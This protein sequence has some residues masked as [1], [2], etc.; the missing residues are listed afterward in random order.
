MNRS[1]SRAAGAP[2]NELGEPM[3]LLDE[4]FKHEV[5]PALGCTEPVACAYATAVA[6]SHLHDDVEEVAVRVDPGT[7][8]NGAA[9]TVPHTEGRKGNLLAAALGAMVAAPEEKLELLRKVTPEHLHRAEEL[10]RTGNC[11]IACLEGERGFRIEAR[12]SSGRHTVLA[13][14][15]HGHTNIEQVVK[16]GEEVLGGEKGDTD[17]NALAYR[18]VLRDTDLHTLLLLAASPGAERTAFLRRGVEMNQAISERGLEMQRTAHQLLRMRKKGYLADDMFFRAKLQ[19]AS[20]VDARMAGVNQAA[21]TSG[22]SGNQG[23]VATLTS[24]IVGKE[25]NVDEGRILESISAAHMMNAYVKCFVGELSVVCGCAMAAGISAAVAI[26]YQQAGVDMQ[27]IT[28][29][30]NSVIGDLGGLICDGAKP[31]CAMKAVTAVDA[32]IRSGLMALEDFGLTDDGLAGRTAEESIRNL[33]RITLEGMFQVD[34][35]ILKILQAKS[36]IATGRAN[37]NLS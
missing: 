22:G 11:K 24:Y 29:A 17:R 34:P 16:D 36:T 19:V 21:M 2:G 32:A 7:L 12:V 28:L 30:V 26:V 4:I 5:Y 23:I 1:L 3:N 20:A 27:K 18:N 9:V 33:G 37:P 13:I 10:C 6:A 15:A 14:L 31:G 25:M 8:K 35:T